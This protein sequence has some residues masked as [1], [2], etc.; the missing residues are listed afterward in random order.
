[1]YTKPPCGSIFK[2]HCEDLSPREGGKW[3]PRWYFRLPVGWSS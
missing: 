3:W 2:N 1:M